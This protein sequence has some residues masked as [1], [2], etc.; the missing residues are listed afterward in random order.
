MKKF[1]LAVK[2][3]IVAHKI[4]SIVI[5]AAAALVIATAVIVPVSVSSA[6]KKKAANQDS[7]LPSGDQTPSGD[8]GGG[9]QGGDQGGD[10]GGGGGSSAAT[11]TITWKDENGTVLETDY[12]VA[13]GTMPTYDGATPTKAETAAATYVFNT[14][15]PEVVAANAD[16]VYTA[17][18]TATT[19]KYAVTWVDGNGDELKTDQVDYGTVPVYSGTD[20]TKDATAAEEYTWN[21]GW[22]EEP[23]AVTGNV[24]YTATFNATPKKY[25][26]T[27]VDGNGN[28]LK[29]DQVNYGEV[30]VYSGADP[31]KN[32]TVE[33]EYTWNHGWN[34]EPVAVTGPATYTA[35]F[36]SAPHRYAITWVDGNGETLKTDQVGYGSVPSYSG[37]TPTKD[38]TVG[39]TFTF[40]DTWSPAPVAVTGPATYTANFDA[41]GR[42]YHV[43]YVNYNGDELQDM[44]NVAYSDLAD[45]VYTGSTPLKPQDAQYT[46]AWDSTWTENVDSENSTVTYTANFTPTTRTYTVTWKD[47]DGNVIHNSYDVPYGTTPEYNGPLPTKEQTAT[48]HYTFNDTW[49]PA[50]GNIT[51]DTEYVAN[52]NEGPALYEARFVNSNGATLQSFDDVEY[53]DPNAINLYNVTPSCPD[54]SNLNFEFDGW[55]EL[56]PDTVNFTRYFKATYHAVSTKPEALSYTFDT[57]HYVVNGFTDHNSKLLTIPAVYNDGVNGEYPVTAIGDN[58]FGWCSDI[59]RITIPA[60]VTSIG[61]FAFGGNSNLVTVEIAGNPTFEDYAFSQCN[62]LDNFTMSGEG[63]YEIKNDAFK[64]CKFSNLTLGPGCTKI[65]Y[66]AFVGCQFTSFPTLNNVTEIQLRAFQDCDKLTSFTFGSS[67]QSIGFCAF[68]GCVG[69]TSIDIPD[70]VT[71]LDSGG[72]FTDCGTISTFK[73]GTG[74][75][76]YDEDWLDGNTRVGAFAVSDGHPT[77]TTIDGVLFTADKSTLVAFPSGRSGAYTI[78]AE[79]TDIVAYAFAN[80]DSLTSITVNEGITTLP[81]GVFAGCGA[82]SIILPDSLISISGYAFSE[83]G[84]KSISIGKNV[85]YIDSKSFVDC[86]SLETLIIDPLNGNYVADGLIIYSS[87]MTKLILSVPSND[88]DSYETP[89]SINYIYDGAFSGS[90]IDSISVGTLG[91]GTFTLGCD[92]FNK[93]TSTSITVGDRVTFI[94]QSAFRESTTLTINL[95]DNITSIHQ[96]AFQE[97]SIESFVMPANCTEIEYCAFYECETLTSFTFN[98]Q[99]SITIDGYAFYGAGFETMT[100]PANV[101]SIGS[102]AFGGC[103]NLTAFDMSNLGSGITEVPSYFF[104]SCYN[105]VNVTFSNYITSIEANAFQWDRELVTINFPSGL[106]E[107][108]YYAFNNCRKLENVTLPASLTTIGAYA[109]G[110]VAVTTFNYAGTASQWAAFKAGRDED[111]TIWPDNEDE[112][113]VRYE[114]TSYDLYDVANR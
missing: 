42:S 41:N 96:N 85:D 109:F 107:I 55:V 74:L 83:C 7:Q 103:E 12:E 98:S 18:Y 100:L 66:N 5:G 86:D 6:K 31:T 50:L 58:A 46:Y 45:L 57:D 65:W 48:I 113:F 16:A 72:V 63:A 104:A 101:T 35:T 76:S 94:P 80:A 20:P 21:N 11:Y 108:C 10:Q 87:D 39:E 92:I 81:S 77:Y 90:K 25:A 78:P 40:N 110:G 8:Q 59:E 88:L 91:T 29:T 36:D 51:G 99:P 68:Q 28:T 102:G 4:I 19:K 97:A 105:L 9:Q 53:D 56:D 70:N 26:I 52:F 33:E 30:P 23:T 89:A 43:R 93:A 1:L 69:L 32:S 17:T 54:D 22:N 60:S 38:N 61:S 73:I 14:W 64:Y 114:G 111:W 84:V 82:Q 106:E 34:I 67:L 15:S 95:T 47:G 3:W 75:T 71:S 112:L 49:T 37:T 44:G 27:W 62:K 79:T 2:G 13:Q 24:T